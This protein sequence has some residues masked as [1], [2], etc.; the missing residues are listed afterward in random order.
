MPPL[1]RVKGLWRPVL[2]SIWANPFFQRADLRAQLLYF[3]AL[4]GRSSRVPGF[5]DRGAA[6]LF[7]EHFGR[8]ISQK[9]LGLLLRPLVDG[10]L[11]VLGRSGIVLPDGIGIT[12][13][14]P[15]QAKGWTRELASHPDQALVGLWQSIND[16][17]SLPESL[18]ERLGEG[19][20]ETTL[21]H[22][23]QRKRE[24]K[25]SEKESESEGRWGGVEPPRLRG[26]DVAHASECLSPEDLAIL[27]AARLKTQAKKP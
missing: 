13:P 24:R 14:N 26:E 8:T 11:M 9:K 20:P 17:G 6:E 5:A 23:S 19:L 27:K 22:K 16:G 2:A 10:Q 12:K 1:G 15:N 3:V 25:E 7:A 21:L 18:G 4:T